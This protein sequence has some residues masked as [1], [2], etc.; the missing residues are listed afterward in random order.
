M[1]VIGYVRVSTEEQA[2][3]KADICKQHS[4]AITEYCSTKG[5]NLLEVFKDSGLSA[6]NMQR[7]GLQKALELVEANKV[8]AFIVYKLDRLTRSL[9]DHIFLIETFA[10]HHVSLVALTESTAN[11]TASEE[12]SLNVRMAAA[13]YERKLIGERTAYAL[14]SLKEKGQPYCRPVFNDRRALAFMR[15]RRAEGISY[16][17]IAWSMAVNGFK[18]TRGGTWTASTVRGI[19]LRK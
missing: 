7:D 5:W 13:Q 4:K 1:D 17:N 12:F 8:Q 9:K 2:E 16:R 19:L 14:K 18:S 10:K 15:E 11:G 3:S 6:K